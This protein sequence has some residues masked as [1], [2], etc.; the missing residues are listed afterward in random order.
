MTIGDYVI[1]EQDGKWFVSDMF[2][3]FEN[4]ITKTIGFFLP[5]IVYSGKVRYFF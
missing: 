2:F 5:D 4:C 3:R 1:S